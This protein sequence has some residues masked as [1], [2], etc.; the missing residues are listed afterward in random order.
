MSRTRQ[1][2]AMAVLQAGLIG[3]A[4]SPAMAFDPG[5][6]TA[7]AYAMPNS[8]RRQVAIE[9]QGGESQRLAQALERV[10]RERPAELLPALIALS[11]RDELPWSLREA[12][13]AQ[14]LAQ[15]ATLEPGAVPPE[16]L[17]YL[18]GWQS[19]T[20]V[21]HEEDAAVGAPLFNIAAQ[22]QG[23]ENRW[24]RKQAEANA[25]FSLQH[26]LA[27]LQQQWSADPD[28]AARAGMVDALSGAAP[29]RLRALATTATATKSAAGDKGSTALAVAAA[30]ALGDR[31]PMLDALEHASETELPALLR[32]LAR[33]DAGRPSFV[34]LR[35]QSGVWPKSSTALAISLWSPQ[36]LGDRDAESWLIGQLSDPELGAAAA[37]ALA[38]IAS[39]FGRA[40][41]QSLATMSGDA[42]LAARAR[43]ALSLKPDEVAP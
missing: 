28:P 14:F 16:A 37:L 2:C 10:R 9:L 1:L 42:R 4:G 20:L 15:L 29:D 8:D 36:W 31:R 41:L 32:A 24:R 33:L 30:I 18:R 22:T 13:I 25:R 19:R 34:L 26:D 7:A 11:E 27:A 40:Q 39:R 43:L 38:R 21:A 5:Q 35:Q 6:A 3:M 17:A 12:A 23:L